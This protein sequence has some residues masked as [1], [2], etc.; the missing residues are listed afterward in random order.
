MGHDLANG[1][2]DNRHK[3]AKVGQLV[4]IAKKKNENKQKI[5]FEFLNLRLLSMF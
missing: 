4:I 1:Q 2:S 3:H 5:I